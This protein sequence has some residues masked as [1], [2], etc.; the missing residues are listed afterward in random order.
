MA[1]NGYLW[2]ICFGVLLNG[3]APFVLLAVFAAAFGSLFPGIP[4]LVFF[5]INIILPSSKNH[6]YTGA[7]G[8]S[9]FLH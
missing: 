8:N 3:W 9:P 7:H 5:Y 2:A 1:V 4:A 6:I